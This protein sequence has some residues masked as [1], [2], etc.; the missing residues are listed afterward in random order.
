MVGL[1]IVSAGRAGYRQLHEDSAPFY[2]RNEALHL[3]ELG[4]LESSRQSAGR[5]P[6]L[7]RRLVRQCA[8]AVPEKPRVRPDGLRIG[9]RPGGAWEHQRDPARQ[10]RA[11]CA[12]SCGDFAGAPAKAGVSCI[13]RSP[14]IPAC[15]PCL[16]SRFDDSYAP[17]RVPSLPVLP[18]PGHQVDTWICPSTSSHFRRSRPRLTRPITDRANRKARVVQ[19]A[20]AISAAMPTSGCRRR[21]AAPAPRRRW[22]SAPRP[23]R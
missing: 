21:E 2:L 1:P 15:A 18:C 16:D 11:G 9:R 13:R 17:L 3:E 22:P 7:L 10:L 19:Q 4:E 23:R 12:G 14:W 5:L 8:A 20:T 6:C